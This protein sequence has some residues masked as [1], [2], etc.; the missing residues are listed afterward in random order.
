M[1]ESERDSI[2]QDSSH[3]RR[4]PSPYVREHACSFSQSNVDRKFLRTW[5]AKRLF[6]DLSK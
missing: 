1:V 5:E 2:S 4:V 3:G 6:Y